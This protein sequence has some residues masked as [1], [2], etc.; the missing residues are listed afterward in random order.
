MMAVKM[1]NSRV[2]RVQEVV[3]TKQDLKIM[4]RTAVKTLAAIKEKI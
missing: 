1:V 2:I 3:A 4:K